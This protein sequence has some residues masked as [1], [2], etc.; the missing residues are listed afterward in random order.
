MQ[1]E[2]SL[3]VGK[4]ARAALRRATSHLACRCC[5]VSVWRSWMNPSGAVAA[6]TASLTFRPL[7]HW[8]SRGWWI[9]LLVHN[10]VL[11]VGNWC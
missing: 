9:A 8:R 3:A 10:L 1:C 5:P 6:G 11:L 7:R 4:R 2:L